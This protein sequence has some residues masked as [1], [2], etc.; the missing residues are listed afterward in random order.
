[1]RN[2]TSIVSVLLVVALLT[3][4]LAACASLAPT[5]RPVSGAD[6]TRQPRIIEIVPP[7]YNRVSS[8][9]G[10][11]AIVERDLANWII[12]DT[13]GNETPLT[14]GD[15]VWLSHRWHE[16]FSEGLMPVVYYGRI[17]NERWGFIDTAGNEVIP[18]T[19][20]YDSVGL[21]SE[22]LAVVRPLHIYGVTPYLRG[23]ID[24][25]GNEVIPPTL[26]AMHLGDFSQGLALIRGAEAD[27]FLFGFID[28]NGNQVVPFR[29]FMATDFSEGLAAVT[30]DNGRWGFIDH[31][32][33]E[34]VRPARRRTYSRVWPLSEG[35][36][37]VNSGWHPIVAGGNWGFIDRAGNVI[38][39]PRYDW[40]Q[41]FNEGFV[42]VGVRTEDNYYRL[43]LINTAGEEVLPPDSADAFLAD[44]IYYR[45]SSGMVSE[46]VSYEGIFAFERDGRWGFA[47]VVW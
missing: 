32:G 2:A 29:Y 46:I 38:V 18:P 22:G 25:A 35:L 28:R 30:N 10:G 24:I 33:N 13:D 31:T 9:S 43:G 3:L 1:M 16:G 15:G 17:G 20:G 27:G 39:P 40:A 36:A 21:L 5:P 47:R 44:R 42:V 14:L 26:S 23:V 19:L 7:T 41:D 45:S 4:S 11:F 8:F 37:R 34:V 6:D 12:I